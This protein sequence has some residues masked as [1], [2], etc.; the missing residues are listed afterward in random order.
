[1]LC[2]VCV[3]AYF[4]FLMIRLPPRS[5]RTDTLFPYTT[6]FRSR[7]SAQRVAAHRSPPARA[8]GSRAR[9]TRT[10]LTMAHPSDEAEFE[11]PGYRSLRRDEPCPTPR[12]HDRR[13]FRK[14]LI[15]DL[16]HGR[17]FRID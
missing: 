1:M 14:Y 11:N 5:T 12:E 3:M 4:F 8:F 15:E 17:D 6:L 2:S 10:G 9:A 13:P 7:R 16:T